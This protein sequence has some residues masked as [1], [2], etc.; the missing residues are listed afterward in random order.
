MYSIAITRDFVASH[1]LI[2]GE[3]G[4][5]NQA[6]DHHYVAEARIVGK[7]LNQH[8]SLVERNVVESALDKIIA[9]FRNELLNNKDEFAGLNPSIER[10]SSIICRKLFAAISPS[11]HGTLR[12]KLWETPHC[13]AS[14]WQDF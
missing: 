5:E 8:G 3:W 12:I 10:F 2:G 11:G 14:F 9:E 6:H 4:E 7:Q 13:S 1:F